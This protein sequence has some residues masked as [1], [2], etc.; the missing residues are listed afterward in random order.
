MFPAIS[1]CAQT[2]TVIFAVMLWR[3]GEQKKLIENYGYWGERYFPEDVAGRTDKKESHLL[4]GRRL[5]EFGIRQTVFSLP[6]TIPVCSFNFISTIY[7]A[8][9][10]VQSTESTFFHWTATIHLDYL[11][12]LSYW[13]LTAPPP[14]RILCCTFIKQFNNKW[15]SIE[16]VTNVIN[17]SVSEFQLLELSPS[18]LICWKCYLKA[19]C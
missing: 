9:H 18:V 14:P 15:I 3:K 13:L 4:V 10:Q 1:P 16:K 7:P 12:L 11:K 8:I 17:K 6:D 19:A 2:T 5:L